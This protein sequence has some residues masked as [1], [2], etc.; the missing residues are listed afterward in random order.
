LIEGQLCVG[1][2]RLVIVKRENRKTEP[3]FP[4]CH[5]VLYVW[6]TGAN[7]ILD[8]ETRERYHLEDLSVGGKIILKCILKNSRYH[9]N[10][11]HRQSAPSFL[12]H[13]KSASRILLDFPSKAQ[14]TG[15]TL[16]NCI[17]VFCMDLITHSDL[18]PYSA[19]TDRF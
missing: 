19:L 13:A 4:L 17:H 3:S 7:S 15:L 11:L 16:K 1:R 8:E 14:V 12:P 9:R 6:T 5:V 10:H 18:F 2:L